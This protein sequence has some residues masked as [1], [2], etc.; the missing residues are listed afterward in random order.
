MIARFAHLQTRDVISHREGIVYGGETS[1]SVVGCSWECFLLGR[2]FL[3]V[4]EAMMREDIAAAY[5]G[6][7][8][9]IRVAFNSTAR[10]KFS[11][12]SLAKCVRVRVGVCACLRVWA[13]VCITLH[14]SGLV[15]VCT[16]ACTLVLSSG[17]P[18]GIPDIAESCQPVN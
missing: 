5:S 17:K 15:P 13:Y 9:H 10:S 11:G 16:P 3:I 18:V 12:F 7:L 4:R 14:M 2:F 1:R 6:F 8:S